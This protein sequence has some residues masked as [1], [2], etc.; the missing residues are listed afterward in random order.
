MLHQNETL[1]AAPRGGTSRRE[2]QRR[3]L[4]DDVARHLLDDI[5]RARYSVGEE[6]PSERDLMEEFGVGRPA[7]REAMS[8]LQRMGLIDIRAGSR[9]RVCKPSASSLLE[10]MGGLV[11]VMLASP[12]TRR[13]L[14]WLRGLFEAALTRFAARVITNAALSEL[15]VNL[16]QQRD[17]VADIS[18]FAKLD[19]HFHRLIAT[20]AG[21]DLVLDL[22]QAL[23]GWLLDQ[24]MVTLR[25]EGQSLVALKA[26]ETIFEALSHRDPDQAEIAMARHLQQIK[27]L[28]QHQSE[29]AS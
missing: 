18:R 5:R 3:R 20:T 8:K 14:Q 13:D 7:V 15:E 10:E 12:E 6:L 28:Y 25:T 17:A 19:M 22:H 24:R 27:E 23:F 2:V 1:L 21:K 29:A 16:S 4:H 11:Q 9:A 26:H